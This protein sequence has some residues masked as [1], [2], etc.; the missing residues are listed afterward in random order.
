MI[1]RYFRKSRVRL[2]KALKD[3]KRTPGKVSNF[4]VAFQRKIKIFLTQFQIQTNSYS[5]LNFQTT[6]I[7]RFGHLWLHS[8]HLHKLCTTITLFDELFSLNFKNNWML[9]AERLLIVQWTFLEFEITVN[10]CQALSFVTLSIFPLNS[11]CRKGMRVSCDY[12]VLYFGGRKLH[13][14]QQQV[15]LIYNILSLKKKNS[16]NFESNIQTWRI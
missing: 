2:L 12:F 16:A 1:D 10:S 13:L 5:T 4:I 3:E 11:S 8:K 9:D 15:V 6:L 14:F 7:V